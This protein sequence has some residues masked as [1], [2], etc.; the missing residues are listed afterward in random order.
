MNQKKKVTAGI[1]H[2]TE[3]ELQQELTRRKRLRAGCIGKV[4][5]LD[6]A[7][8]SLSTGSNVAHPKEMC[9]H[10]SVNIL[11]K[12]SGAWRKCPYYEES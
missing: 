2:Y 8:A 6:C 11:I 4:R 10:T 7:F 9:T 5:C 3:D 1:Q 12:A